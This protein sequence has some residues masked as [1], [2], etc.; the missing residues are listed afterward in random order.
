MAAPR[1]DELVTNCFK[2]PNPLGCMHPGPFGLTK[3]QV[4]DLATTGHTECRHCKEDRDAYWQIREFPRFGF[5]EGLFGLDTLRGSE[6]FPPSDEHR[7]LVWNARDAVPAG[8]RVLYANVTGVVNEL[9]CAGPRFYAMQSNTSVWP[10]ERAIH[11]PPSRLPTGISVLMV[12]T[13]EAPL[14]LPRDLAIQAVGLFHAQ[15]L[16]VACVLLAAAAEAAL[17]ARLTLEYAARRV[18]LP[19]NH[20]FS[21]LL[22]CAR[23]LLNPQP[24]PKLIGKLKELVNLARNPTAHGRAVDVGPDDVAMWMVDVAVLYEWTRLAECVHDEA[25]P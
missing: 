8:S 21:Q 22:E 24:G 19:S 17:R 4:M 25:G 9:D 5:P 6:E 12:V 15:H 3:R 13:P 20:A 16:N 7:V 2:H 23:L 11:V 18:T 1:A 10:L 14:D